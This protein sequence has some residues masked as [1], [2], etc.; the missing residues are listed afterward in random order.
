M[1]VAQDAHWRDFYALW[2]EVACAKGIRIMTPDTYRL[3]Q[4][5]LTE[6]RLG[7]LFVVCEQ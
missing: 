1:C 3:L 4:L 5:H 7:N 6:N 2:C